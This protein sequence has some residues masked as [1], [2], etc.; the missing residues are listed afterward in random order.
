MNAAF[1]ACG[2]MLACAV[3]AAA[4]LGIA[5]LLA[6]EHLSAG[7]LAERTATLPDV[8]EVVLDLLCTQ[9]VFRRDE[10]GRFSNTP[11]SEPL[12][13]DHPRSMRH[14]CIL[15]SA[16]YQQAFGALMVTLSTG[17]SGFRATFNGSIYDYMTRNPEPG[18]VYDLAMEDLSRPLSAILASEWPFAEAATLLDLG[19][20][21]GVLLR[22]L[23]RARPDLRGVCF[24]RRDVCVRGD[25]DLRQM[26]PDLVGRLRFLG[27]DFFA[28]VLPDA[29]VYLLKN[30]I[31]NWTDESAIRLLANVANALS[32]RSNARLLVIE[33]LTDGGFSETYRAIDAL[34]ARVLCESGTRLRDLNTLSRLVESSGLVVL[35]AN[36][37][38]TGHTL[39]ECA[40]TSVES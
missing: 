40:G 38:S 2:G 32:T 5:D 18:R 1:L 35:R 25:L 7:A 15:A 31:H 11:D 23:L 20:G 27:G 10:A 17:E 4:R 24:D 21:H 13:S 29:D 28:D 14:F 9:G 6:D 34:L 30:V 19:G 26:A 3:G 36:V 37:L 33:S 39:L 16:E 22:G 12:R 8:L